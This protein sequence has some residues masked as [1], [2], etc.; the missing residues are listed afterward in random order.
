[1]INK[2]TVMSTIYL[3]KRQNLKGLAIF[4]GKDVEQE[5]PSYTANG[6]TLGNSLTVPQN[7]TE[8][9]HDLVIPFLNSIQEK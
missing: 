7:V 9:P 2:T 4:I 8:L 6:A 3:L 1:M 5:E